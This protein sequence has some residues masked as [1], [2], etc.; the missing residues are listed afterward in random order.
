MDVAAVAMVV[1]MIFT[2]TLA[3]GA[4]GQ[5]PPDTMVIYNDFTGNLA[6]QCERQAVDMVHPKGYHKFS[7]DPNAQSQLQCTFNTSPG[8][9][10]PRKGTFVMW[11]RNASF[12][13]CE[14]ICIWNV[15]QSGLS[16]IDAQGHPAH[17]YNWG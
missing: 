9:A 7:F 2:I 13:P 17:V 4:N 16:I 1:A 6:V 5:G 10:P 8:V 3:G 14:H 11:A 15:D 12:K